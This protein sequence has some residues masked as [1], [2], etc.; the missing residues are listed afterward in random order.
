MLPVA[1]FDD[2]FIPDS[3]RPWVA[4]IS[5]RMQCPREYVAI[6]AIVALGATWGRKAAIAPQRRTDW[7]E[8]ANQWAM[9]VGRPGAMKS[10]AAAEALK[11]LQ[12]L[13]A[14][15]QKDNET[16]ER[17][18]ANELALTKIKNDEC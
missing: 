2:G 17:E 8:V 14:E 5:D 9:F 18:H 15:A 7:R 12:R 16:A 3:I 11:P 4:D 6:P 1:A 10:P 13:E